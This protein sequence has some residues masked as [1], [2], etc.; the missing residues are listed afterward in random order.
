VRNNF[1]EGNPVREPPSL[2]LLAVGAAGLAALRR[3]RAN[4]NLS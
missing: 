4:P 1:G 3:K 2:V